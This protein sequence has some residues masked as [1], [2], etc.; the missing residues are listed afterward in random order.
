[1]SNSIAFDQ[2][3]EYYDQTRAVP[4]EVEKQGV[5][6]IA[7]ALGLEAGARVLE[8][9][10]GTG[11]WAIPLSR[12]G[13]CYHG[14]DISMPML[15][16]LVSKQPPV[17]APVMLTQGDVTSLPYR[18]GSF[19]GVLVVHVFH[20]VPQYRQAIA[21]VRRVL[22]RGGVA[23]AVGDGVVRDD[24]FQMMVSRKL[25]EFMAEY[26]YKH[27][28][29]FESWNDVLTTMR[30]GASQLDDYTAFTWET[31]TTARA[32]YDY[33]AARR[34][35]WLWQIPDAAFQPALAE[36]RNWLEAE[37]D[38]DAPINRVRDFKIT[39]VVY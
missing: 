21:E 2:A 20:L 31:L 38:M 25:G 23:L 37:Y 15:R 17:D 10:V 1:M 22:Q 34:W 19:A 33:I 4:P 18:D 8:A 35:S 9:G 29:V 36:L 30:E 24:D 11:R 27:E 7:A 3:A 28:D 13:Y 39:K 6:A 5:D 12:R 32:E 26:G 14:L 16:K